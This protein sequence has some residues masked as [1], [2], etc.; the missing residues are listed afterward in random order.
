MLLGGIVIWAIGRVKIGRNRSVTG[1][2]ARVIA[3]ILILPIPLSI[4]IELII[5]ERIRAHGRQPTRFETGIY[6][7]ALT[8][9]CLLI[10][11]IIALFAARRTEQK[12]LAGHEE[13]TD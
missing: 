10:A 12:K 4:L 3:C 6:D 13:K 7:D 8:T 11:L 5:A 9:G 2:A 1:V